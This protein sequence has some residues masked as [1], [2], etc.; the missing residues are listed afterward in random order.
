MS[1]D[2]P[3][4][5]T[6]R[7]SEKPGARRGRPPVPRSLVL[8]AADALF[9]ETDAQHAVSM[10]EI[11]AAAGV[12]KGTVF[13]AFGSRDNLLDALFAS[14]MAAL[15]EAVESG[16]PPVGP[17]VP[18]R[19]RVLAI[20]DALLTFKLDNRRL[21]RAREIASAGLFQAEHYRW[22]HST[23]RE[24]IEQATG[25]RPQPADADGTA[26]DGADAID[27][28]YAAHVLLGSLRPDLIDE[29]LEAGGTP[30]SIRRAQKAHARRILD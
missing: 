6:D 23:L 17:G 22:M 7:Q 12:G 10:D 29:L 26:P 2:Y 4:T 13:R 25:G 18:P 8:A 5:F 27:P 1:P 24:L 20:L 16:A 15:R 28:G 11:A 9:A 3:S 21:I 30:E 14:R 19:E